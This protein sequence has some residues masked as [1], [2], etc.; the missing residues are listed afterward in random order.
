MFAVARAVQVGPPMDD[1]FTNSQL[2]RLVSTTASAAGPFELQETV[3]PRFAH[4]ARAQR[5]PDGTVIIFGVT[6]SVPLVATTGCSLLHNESFPLS[7]L[8][9]TLSWAPSVHGP[10]QHKTLFRFHE[11]EPT[12]PYCRMEAPVAAFAPNGTVIMVFNAFPCAPTPWRP[13]VDQLYVATA[14]HWSGPYRRRI[15]LGPIVRRPGFGSGTEGAEDPVS[16][17]AATN[18]LLLAIALSDAMVKRCLVAIL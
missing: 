10:W 17:A 4:E 15:D 2:V 11:G 8:A 14:P 12:S 5:A 7:Q 3:L 6:G 1:Y 13:R 9:L 18:N 16:E